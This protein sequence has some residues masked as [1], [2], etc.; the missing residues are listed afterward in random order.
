MSNKIIQIEQCDEGYIIT[1]EP[2]KKRYAITKDGLVRKIKE[3]FGITDKT[4][5]KA[6]TTGNKEQEG[7]VDAITAPINEIGDSLS[8]DDPARIPTAQEPKVEP[9][10]TARQ[11]IIEL[12]QMKKPDGILIPRFEYDPAQAQ[13]TELEGYSNISVVEL[14]DGRVM[15]QYKGTHYY[16]TKEKVMQLPYPAPYSYFKK[17]GM[18][19]SAVAMTCLRAYRQYLHLAAIVKEN[20]ETKAGDADAPKGDENGT[21]DDITFDS[22]ANNSPEN[23]KYCVNESRYEDKN[24]LAAKKP[25]P[26]VMRASVPP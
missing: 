16:T 24:K 13:R 4:V 11:K 2:T 12:A 21:C 5:H 14:P 23:C 1:D 8:K 7:K 6:Q 19:L 15:I 10:I 25:A 9:T 18:G 20:Q 17:K 3:L 22:C 26:P